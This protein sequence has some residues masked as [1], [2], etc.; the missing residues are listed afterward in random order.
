MKVR[1]VA[2]TVLV[3]LAVSPPPSARKTPPRPLYLETPIKMN[4]AKIP[5]GMYELAVDSSG[6]AVE[7]TLWR[8]GKFFATAHGVWVKSGVKFTENA[9][10]L[11]VNSDG[12]RSLIEIRLAGA[13]KSIVLNNPDSVIRISS[14]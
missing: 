14:K 11:R 9:V 5:E 10:L 6:S 4:G 7:V 1:F 13:S 2:L 3:F 12:T 8:D